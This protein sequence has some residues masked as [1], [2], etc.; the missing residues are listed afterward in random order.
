[1]ARSIP[2][3]SLL[4]PPAQ[5]QPW[6]LDGCTTPWPRTCTHWLLNLPADP[7]VRVCCPL[8]HTQVKYV[9][10]T[11]GKWV[12]LKDGAAATGEVKVMTAAQADALNKSS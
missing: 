3:G 12:P 11:T 7:L 4:A 5:S 6:L 10:D 1:M 8:P 2:P 9:L